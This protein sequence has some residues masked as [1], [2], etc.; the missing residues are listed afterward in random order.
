[1]DYQGHGTHVAGIAAAATNN[2]TGIASI[3]WGCKVMPLR[4]GFRMKDGTG[5]GYSSSIALAFEYAADHGASVASLSF[6]TSG[7]M[8]VDGARYA[9]L[10]GVVIC[11]AAGNSNDESPG[12]L[13]TQPWVLSVA[14][15]SDQDKKASYSTYGTWVNISSPGGDQSASRP[16]ILS[17]IVN[18]SAFYGGELYVSF[19]GTSMACPLVAGLAGLVKSKYPAM[20]AGDIV[21]QIC[22]TADNIDGVNPVY[23][24]KL[25]YGRINAQ[26]AVTRIAPA[27]LPNLLFSSVSF[28]DATGNNNG[29]V[30]P[31]ETIEMAVFFMNVWDNASNTTATLSTTAWGI[32]ITKASANYGTIPGIRDINNS[33]KGNTSDRFIFTVSPDSIPR[34]VTFTI[35]IAADQGYTK[36]FD[37]KIS[38]LPNLLFVD[39][40]DGAVNTEQ[41]YTNAFNNLGLVCDTW[42]HAV[43]GSLTSGQLSAYK[44]VVWGCEWAFPSL[45]SAD[46]SAIGGFL[47]NGGQL[48]I[49]GQ[50]IGWDMCASDG[51]E[52]ISSGGTSKTWYETYFKSQYQQDNAGTTTLSGVASD[53]I[54]NNLTVEFTEPLRTSTEQYPDVIAPLSGAQS[55]FQYST[56]G[57]GAVRYAS[58]HKVVYFSFGGFEAISSQT[59]RDTVMD[60]I[61]NWF[62]GFQLQHTPLK[63]TESPDSRL[64]R[65]N[66]AS[67]S[68]II[69]VNLYWDT[70]GTFPFNKVPMQ[71]IGGGVYEGYIPGQTSATVQYTVIVAT[72]NGC[73]PY[74]VNSYKVGVDVIAPV[75]LSADSLFGTLTTAGLF[76]VEASASDNIAVD[77][78][79]TYIVFKVN[80]SS[81]DST[82][83]QFV[84]PN[85]YIGTLDVHSLVTKLQ[86]GDIVS[87]YYSIQDVSSMHNYSRYP[88]VGFYS[89]TVGR[90]LI[91]NFEKMRSIWNFGLSWGYESASGRTYISDSPPIGT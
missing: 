8:V 82:R 48:F 31:G 10:N 83:L 19:Q 87:Y 62:N 42:N 16:G 49:S 29:K 28:S 41:Y 79:R 89:F 3:S 63:D 46:R 84:T 23:A 47:D 39:D 64:V 30:D 37:V 67:S 59:I 20:N 71:A 38:I 65:V 81:L 22:A 36:N 5:S 73:M 2:S 18:P 12:I 6:G 54:G 70:D 66:I 91:D 45:D 13:G 27:M 69:S 32:N 33:T 40:D 43:Q 88:S 85:S 24:G 4:I 17:T 35:S 50:D 75:F 11:N 9:Y 21:L 80:G 56:S 15:V 25:G 72:V 90:Q 14:S 61:F 86:H 51:T 58:T 7:A 60:R 77:T 1:M 26:S 74:R 76:S 52:F 78:N 44:T 68:S 53:P 55:I 57:S 34:S